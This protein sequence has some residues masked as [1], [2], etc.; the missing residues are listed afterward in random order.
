MAGRVV[1][2]KMERSRPGHCEE[3]GVGYPLFLS[4]WICSTRY[5]VWMDSASESQRHSP[6][7]RPCFASCPWLSYICPKGRRAACML[8]NGRR[9]VFMVVGMVCC[10]VL[11]A[12]WVSWFRGSLGSAASRSS[13]SDGMPSPLAMPLHR[14]LHPLH[15]QSHRKIRADDVLAELLLLQELEHLERRGRKG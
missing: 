11:L 8:A 2:W 13:C 5:S 14:R 15:H 6:F 4:R 7:I 10:G 12:R 1:E 3:F 9:L